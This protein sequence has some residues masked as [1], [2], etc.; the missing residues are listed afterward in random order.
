MLASGSGTNLQ[1][2]IDTAEVR[3]HITMVVSD[4]HDA[5]AL[6]RAEEADIPRRVVQF[7]D[8]LDR[9]AFSATL[10][11]VVEDSGAK[12]VVLAGFMRVLSPVFVDRFPGR[13][14]NIHPSLLP[15]FPGARAVEAALAAG[16]EVTGVTVHFVDYQVDQGPIVAQVEVPIVEGDDPGTLHR[17]IQEVEHLLYPE[18]VKAFV[19]GDLYLDGARVVGP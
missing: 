8:H 17:R 11:D 13:I 15:A 9:E 18:L 6:T 10:A 1:A 19:K 4:R 3:A 16:V 5:A 14:L 2:L 7:A 12:G